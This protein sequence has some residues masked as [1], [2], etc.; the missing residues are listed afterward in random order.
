MFVT[1]Q[2]WHNSFIY[3]LF[4][5]LYVCMYAE[6]RQHYNNTDKNMIGR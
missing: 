3:L 1:K 5:Y 2:H 4:I 6:L